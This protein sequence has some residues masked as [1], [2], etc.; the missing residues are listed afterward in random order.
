LCG[1]TGD[2]TPT[3]EIYV[4][5]GFARHLWM[6]LKDAAEEYGVSARGSGDREAGR[7][8]PT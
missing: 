1:D 2:P 8:L 4:H 5:R 3:Y 6:W 7:R